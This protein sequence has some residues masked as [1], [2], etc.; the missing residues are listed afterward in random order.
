[1]PSNLFIWSNTSWLFPC[2]YIDRY[3]FPASNRYQGLQS[4]T[5]GTNSSDTTRMKTASLPLRRCQYACS[6]R[7][8]SLC[9]HSP[10]SSACEQSPKC[11][12][13]LAPFADFDSGL[14]RRDREKGGKPHSA[15]G[16]QVYRLSE[17]RK[18]Y[19]QCR[20]SVLLNVLPQRHESWEISQQT[21]P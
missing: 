17:L 13:G 1:M 16:E 14:V 20:S 5:L 11:C 7:R 3:C 12:Q 6:S 18:S 10:F 9:L 15:C 4:K 19:F 8:A 2:I 21:K